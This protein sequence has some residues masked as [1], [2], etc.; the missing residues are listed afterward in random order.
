MITWGHLV[1]TR[2]TGGHQAHGG[3]VVDYRQLNEATMPHAHPLPL[4]DNWLATQS[5]IVTIVDLSKGFHRM[6][7]GAHTPGG[8]EGRKEGKCIREHRPRAW[9]RSLPACTLLIGRVAGRLLCAF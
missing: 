1:L 6:A 7:E 4:V 5:K 9:G 2:F 8:G 3:G